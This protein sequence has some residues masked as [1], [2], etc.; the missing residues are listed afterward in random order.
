MKTVELDPKNVL[1]AEAKIPHDAP[2]TMINLV[3]FFEEAQYE[4][5]SEKPCSGREAYMQRYA[6]AFNE[7]AGVLKVDGIEVIY[8]G[9]VAQIILGPSDPEW[10]AIAIVRYPSFSALRTVTES[11]LYLEKAEPHRKAALKAW[12]FIA[13]FQPSTDVKS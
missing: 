2:V 9:A 11:A 5:A 8:V 4:G 13:T 12:E 1:A 6:P 7:V 10:D 3:Q